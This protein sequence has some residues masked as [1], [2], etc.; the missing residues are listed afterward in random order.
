MKEEPADEEDG[1]AENPDG[2]E[3]GETPEEEA[4]DV[5]NN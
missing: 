2:T 1:D 5:S 4:D 3:T